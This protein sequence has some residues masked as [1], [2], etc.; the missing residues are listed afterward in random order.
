MNPILVTGATGTVGREIVSILQA[1]DIPVRA[2]ARGAQGTRAERGVERVHLTSPT[3][4]RTTMPC[5]G[6]AGSS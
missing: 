1:R 5:V 2:A 6:C 3:A 4:A